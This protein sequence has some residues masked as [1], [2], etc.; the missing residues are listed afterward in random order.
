MKAIEQMFVSQ[1]SFLYVAVQTRTPLRR[2]QPDTSPASGEDKKTGAPAPRAATSRRAGR[3]KRAG[4]PAPRPRPLL[5][6]RGL[7][8]LLYGL[9]HSLLDFLLGSHCHHL[10]LLI[11][12]IAR[13]SRASMTNMTKKT[14][15]RKHFAR[16]RN[17]EIMTIISSP[18]DCHA[19]PGN[20]PSETAY[21]LSRP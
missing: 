21:C 5:L 18:C 11:R 1:A 17:L 8:D 15:S 19:A 16:G 12:S 13:S 14:I 7:L 4:A 20:H 3:I 10:L 2:A 6:L 9:L